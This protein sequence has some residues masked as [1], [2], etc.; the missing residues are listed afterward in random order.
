MN[1]LKNIFINSTCLTIFM[2]SSASF[3]QSYSTGV[4]TFTSGFTCEIQVN[5]DSNVVTMTLVG[6]AN[7]WLGVAF[8]PSSGG[9]G[10]SGDDLVVYTNQGL[11][12]RAMS[13]GYSTPSIDVVNNW[14]VDDDT[15]ENGVRTL[16][17]SRSRISS[18]NS[19]YTFPNTPQSITLL[20]AMGSSLNFGYHNSRGAFVATLSTG[21]YE[22]SDFSMYPN[23]MKDELNLN[24]D[25]YMSSAKFTLF[26]NLGQ[27]VLRHSFDGK[28][29]KINTESLPSGMYMMQLE[30]DGKEAIRRLIKE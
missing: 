20:W 18:D 14:D 6:P 22:L 12:D 28:D 7:R 10:S 13:G 17:V 2:F 27:E 19:D 3:G 5:N 15:T 29:T 30:G 26:N 25:Q 9:M 23:P 4:M 24:F 1:T 16:I 21:Q 8:D 11:Q